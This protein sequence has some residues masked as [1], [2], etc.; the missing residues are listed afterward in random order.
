MPNRFWRFAL[1]LLLATADMGG[2]QTAAAADRWVVILVGIGGD[3]DYDKKYAEVA[4]RWQK[5]FQDDWKVRVDHI[6]RP[7]IPLTSTTIE[8]LL[9]DVAKKAQ[10]DDSIWLLT[11]GHGDH[12]GRHARF[13]VSG[14]DPIES[15]WPRWLA[16]VKC[17]EQ[18]LLFTHS[19]SGHLVKP[20]SKPGRVVIAATEADAEVNETEFPYALAKV[21]ESPAKDLDA[22]TDGKI[23]LAELFAKVVA[24][25]N[26]RFTT[27]KR[28]PTE[29]AQLD[30]DG[31]GR[32][33]EELTPANANSDDAAA[34]NAQAKDG[35]LS[36]TIF[37]PWPM[38]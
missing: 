23:S 7:P 31:D 8:Q 28:L 37:L 6:V 5:S 16:E 29:H 19:S 13:H 36:R 3:A 17:R 33:S 9:G 15:D 35:A 30:D 32:G 27:D 1:A 25:T 24:A 22:D 4:D 10:P 34:K 21:L 14:R 26:E 18:V 12:D 11:L 38:K 2:A 20:L